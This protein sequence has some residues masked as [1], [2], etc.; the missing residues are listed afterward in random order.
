VISVDEGRAEIE[1]A[2][3][4][5]VLDG[6]PRGHAS[7]PAQLAVNGERFATQILEAQIGSAPARPPPPARREA[8]RSE[9]PGIPAAPAS[10][11]GV[12]IYPPM[13]G[14]ILE[15]HVTEGGHVAAGALLLVLEAM[16]MRNEITSPVA[17][18]VV[19]LTA[20]AGANVR[21]RELLLRIVPDEGRS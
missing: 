7:P 10:A 12:P 15:V 8:G 17:G 19:G 20:A 16:K 4:K 13:P 18:R 14:R 1:I 11:E 6:W 2:G 21:A 9:G 3:E 5:I